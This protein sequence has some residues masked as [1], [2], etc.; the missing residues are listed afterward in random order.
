MINDRINIYVL[1]TN[2][3]QRVNFIEK[4][5]A[6]VQFEFVQSD[7]KENL[8]LLENKYRKVSHQFRVKAMMLG[9]IGAFDTH[10]MAWK[11]IKESNKPGI[12]IE[13]SSDFIRD[14][15]FLESDEAYQLIERCGLI[16]FSDYPYKLHHDKPTLFSDI[17]L[18]KAFPV[19]CYGL[20]PH[21]ARILL[22]AM[23]KNAYVMPVD[24]WLSIPKLSGVL[25]FVSHIGV[26]VR[27]E[28]LLSIANKTKGKK[29]L[30]PLNLIYRL[31]NK[32]KYKY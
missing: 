14:A 23:E 12:I 22:N 20:T 30:N 6:K 16:S 1:T 13:D 29:S 32:L 26:A 11:K 15:S 8:T 5:M 27:K 17:P 2:D 9:E 31:K 21:R 24:K 7:S 4:L 19:R 25:G 28:N 3:Q 10:S 18:K